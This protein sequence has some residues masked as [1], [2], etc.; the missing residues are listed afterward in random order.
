MP[1]LPPSPQ[2]KT[3]S[4][5][6]ANARNVQPQKKPGAPKPKG[7]VRAKS[8]CYT[9]R[10]RRKKCDEQPNGEGACQTCVRL[11]LQCLG[12][13]AKRPDWMRENNSVTELREKIKTF[14]ASQGMIKGHSGS[15]PRSNE[16]EPQVL[17]LVENLQPNPPGSP[18]TPTLSATSSDTHRP[19]QMTSYVRENGGGYH[20]APP[21]MPPEPHFAPPQTRLPSNG[22]SAY[23]QYPPQPALESSFSPLYT[24]NF[25]YG[26]DDDPQEPPDQAVNALPV[27]MNSYDSMIPYDQKDLVAHYMQKVLPIQY[28]LSDFTSINKFIYDLI[29]SSES[30]RDAACMLAAIHRDRMGYVSPTSED[31][32]VSHPANFLYERLFQGLARKNQQYS[33]GDAMAGLHAVSTI[34]FSGGRGAW[35]MFLNV[36]SQYVVGIL[37]DPKYYGPEDVLLRCSESTRFIIKTTMWFDVLASVTTQQVPRFH[38]TYRT[39][40]DRST[41]AYIEDPS[42]LCAPEISMLPVMGCENNIVLAIAEISSLAHWKESQRRRNCLSIPKLVERGTEIENK[43]LT[44]GGMSSP[45]TARVANGNLAGS[46]SSLAAS[47]AYGLGLDTQQTMGLN[48][49]VRVVNGRNGSTPMTMYTPPTE[50]ELRRQLTNDI[51]RASARVYLHTVLSGDHPSCPEIIDAVTDTINCL[52]RVPLDKPQLSRS[53]LRSV[54]FGICISG[55]LTDNRDQRAFLMR[56][57]QTQQS[58]SVGNVAEV[59]DLMQQ[60]W[61]RRD[62]NRGAPVNWR[63]VMR[64]SQRE[65]LLLV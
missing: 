2:R 17:V 47:G 48:G 39:L 64:E 53:V 18:P 45:S 30:A 20:H 15:G 33:E 34:L 40:F 12:F 42:K 52:R 13:G 41:R 3:V 29:R 6:S 21:S 60:V 24:Q 11:R 9:C 63:D 7:A 19:P 1:D 59:L 37:V 8:G 10:I 54:V 36:A 4:S 25:A 49:H 38:Q 28:L 16:G 27:I 22:S 50:V 51:F 58:E 44:P 35:D 43:Y 56:L 61:Q 62:S 55:C 32:I 5:A 31:G 23:A 46:S 57:L 65:L 26:S 14:L